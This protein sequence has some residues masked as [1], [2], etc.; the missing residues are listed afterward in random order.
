MR[1]CFSYAA[2]NP[3]SRYDANGLWDMG[4]TEVTTIAIGT[5]AGGGLIV[6]IYAGGALIGVTVIFGGTWLAVGS[7]DEPG[8]GV[9]PEPQ[10]EFESEPHPASEPGVP[11]TSGEFFAVQTR[12]S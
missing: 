1:G 3:I 2:G 4:L 10:T 6:G 8:A 11:M 5:E 12:G 9:A 7:M